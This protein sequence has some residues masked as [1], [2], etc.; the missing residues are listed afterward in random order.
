MQ[1]IYEWHTSVSFGVGG[2]IFLFLLVMILFTTGLIVGLYHGWTAHEKH[3]ERN[4]FDFE[5]TD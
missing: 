4:K 3:L 5:K 2:I 1:Q